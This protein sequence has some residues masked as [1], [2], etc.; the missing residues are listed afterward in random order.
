MKAKRLRVF[1]GPNGSGKTT[2]I[3]TLKDKIPFGVYVNADDIEALLFKNG[4]LDFNEYSIEVAESE[5]QEFFQASNF[6]AMKRNEEDLADK[7]KVEANR[8]FIQTK[9]DSYLS[10]GIADFIRN[11]LLRKGISLS[12]ETVMSHESKVS[13]MQQARDSG[14]RVYLYFIATSD[15]AINVNRVGVR[16]AQKGHPV[17]KDVIVRRYYRSL[18]LLRSAI[19]HSNRAYLFDN[20]GV[21]ANLFAEITNGIDVRIFDLD[22]VPNWFDNYLLE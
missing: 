7:L 13:F 18:E 3:R 17:A 12:F 11:S 5:I 10:A 8:L 14:Y 4:F 20:S 16:V 2:I 15:P 6:S 1:A 19:R 22:L 21:T 9:P